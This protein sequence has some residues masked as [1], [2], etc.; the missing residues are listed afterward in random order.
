VYLLDGVLLVVLGLSLVRLG[1]VVHLEVLNFLGLAHLSLG[2]HPLGEN[3]HR[4]EVFF[5][6]PHLVPG[7]SSV[8]L[9]LGTYFLEGPNSPLGEFLVMGAVMLLEMPPS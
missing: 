8:R 3:F 2:A 9:T 4:G 1:A 7:V 5:L 6:C